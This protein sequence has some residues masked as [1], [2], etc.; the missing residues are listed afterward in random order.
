MFAKNLFNKGKNLENLIVARDIIVSMEFDI[1]YINNL[2]V[3]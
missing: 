2:I 3:F 1:Y